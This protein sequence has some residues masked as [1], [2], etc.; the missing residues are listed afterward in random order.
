MSEARATTHEALDSTARCCDALEPFPGPGSLRQHDN[1]EHEMFEDLDL[2]RMLLQ[3]I[4][5]LRWLPT[6][7][8]DPSQGGDPDETEVT[9]DP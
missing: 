2:A 5:V 8:T 7:P 9:P 3:L 6:A 1:K 4:Y